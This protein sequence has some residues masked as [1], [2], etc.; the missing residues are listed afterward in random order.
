MKKPNVLNRAMFNQG[1]TS[2]YGK[3]ITSNLV[4]DEQRQRYN[5]GGRVGV[6]NG[7]DPTSFGQNPLLYRSLPS[8]TYDFDPSSKYRIDQLNL[9]DMYT[10]E[11]LYPKWEE[12]WTVRD[13]ESPTFGTTDFNILKPQW[14]AQEEAMLRLKE[15]DPVQYEKEY[16]KW[17]K[18]KGYDKKRTKQE[19]LFESAGIT[20]DFLTDKPGLV[21]ADTGASTFDGPDKEVVEKEFIS[22][23]PMGDEMWDQTTVRDDTDELDTPD[24]W[25]FLDENMAKKKKLARGHALMEGAAAAAD[26][27]VAATPEK[28]GAAVSKGLRGVGTIGAKYKGEAEDIKTKAKIL[29]T[30]EDIKGEQKQKLFEDRRKGYYEPSLELQREGLEL[31]K[32]AARLKEKGASNKETYVALSSAGK[33]NNPSAKADFLSSIINKQIQV[34]ADEKEIKQLS[35]P[36]NDGVI[37]IDLK[38]RIWRNTNGEVKVVDIWQDKEFLGE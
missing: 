33:L 5:Y 24:K 26:F 8:G 27:A 1:G 21:S 2:A 4:S 7:G 18:E 6:W 3:G 37:F 22:K 32:E 38:G 23:S 28:R 30:V 20:S 15:E 9:E 29:G 11:N 25:A 14:K 17:V 34:A 31:K 10:R 16:E 36:E 35:T 13:K 19:E 12:S